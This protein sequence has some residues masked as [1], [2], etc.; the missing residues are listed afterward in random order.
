MFNVIITSISY[1][2]TIWKDHKVCLG[3]KSL[4][5][6]FNDSMLNGAWILGNLYA[7]LL[8]IKYLRFLSKLTFSTSFSKLSCLYMDK[9]YLEGQYIFLRNDFDTYTKNLNFY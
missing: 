8:A 1:F 3:I 6:T 2:E 4:K 7:P 9:N 5:N